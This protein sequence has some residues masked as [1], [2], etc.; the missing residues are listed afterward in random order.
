[1]IT[2]KFHLKQDEEF[3]V[4]T[5][6]APYVKAQEVDIS[7]S[8]KVFSFYCKPYFLRL[9]FENSLAEDGRESASYNADSSEFVVSVPKKIRGEVFND[10]TLL[11][12]LLAP[13]KLRETGRPLIE[14]LSSAEGDDGGACS[15][16]GDDD[17][18]WYVEQ[19]PHEASPH[20]F[21]DLPEGYGFGGRMSGIWVRLSEHASE[22]LDIREPD[23]LT[24][25]QRKAFQNAQEADDFNEDHY[26]ADLYDNPE[27]EAILAYTPWF[28]EPDLAVDELLSQKRELMLSLPRRRYVLNDAQKRGCYL[29]LID[30]VFVYCYNCRVTLGEENVE[31]SW[32]IRKLSA[33]LS[34]L[35][36]YTDVKEVAISC[37][38][39]SLCYPLV[40]NWDVSMKVLQ[41]AQ[42]ILAAGKGA[43]LLCLLDVHR[44]FSSSDPYYVLNDLYI[45]DMCV[46]IQSASDGKVRSL[47]TA[48]SDV[49]I[50]KAD[51]SLNL[52]VLE[53][54]AALAVAATANAPS[55]DGSCDSTSSV[56]GLSDDENSSDEECSSGSGSSS[57]SGGSSDAECSSDNETDCESA[58]SKQLLQSPSKHL[59]S[60]EESQKHSLPSLGL[61]DNRAE[62]ADVRLTAM[63]HHLADLCIG[64]EKQTGRK[65]I[66]ELPPI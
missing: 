32:N 37:I 11:T 52:L 64:S 7:I 21:A 2:P 40:R 23:K 61:S 5:V 18:L 48:I 38:R 59:A 44:M 46:W 29:G 3:V 30:L 26:L 34:C 10:L 56:D 13:P 43:V 31:C 36:S 20:K 50:S 6:Y 15:D 53:Q 47:S 39:R 51:V 42:L 1:M 12:K 25:D 16:S 57:S 66:E 62:N 54:A 49:I 19:S 35:V 4:V 27:L 60:C 33:L 14:D 28:R 63:Q 24:L 58:T 9:S 22:L 45:T 55:G 17:S 65:L 8:D 41:D